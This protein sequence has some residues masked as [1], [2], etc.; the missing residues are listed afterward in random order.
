MQNMF[1]NPLRLCGCG[2]GVVTEWA[3]QRLT[4]SMVILSKPSSL[5]SFHQC[6]NLYLQYYVQTGLCNGFS[7][8]G[9]NVLN[10]PLWV[11][12]KFN[13]QFLR[14]EVKDIYGIVISACGLLNCSFIGIGIGLSIAMT[15]C[16]IFAIREQTK[17]TDPNI[18][19]SVAFHFQFYES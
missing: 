11:N 14:C 10:S 5:S 9:L 12:K 19:T 2:G 18:S 15:V 1:V 8:N 7:Q 3:H 6:H 4:P 13:F 17:M 16:R